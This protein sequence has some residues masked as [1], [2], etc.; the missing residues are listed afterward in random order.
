[1][2]TSHYIYIMAIMFL[3]TS[4]TH[5]RTSCV[6]PSN[7]D[8]LVISPFNGNEAW[9]EEVQYKELPQRISVEATEQLKEYIEGTKIFGKVIQ[10]TDCV[11][12]SLKVDGKLSSL[13]HHRGFNITF[14][15]KIFNCQT[16]E[17]LFRFDHNLSDSG[18]IDLPHKIM[19]KVAYDIENIMCVKQ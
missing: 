3:S 13:T 12:R 2:K 7:I 16:G 10:S 14:R 5:K 17:T 19:E 15:G 18:A 6:S 9:V 1:M 4:C 8:N 11:D